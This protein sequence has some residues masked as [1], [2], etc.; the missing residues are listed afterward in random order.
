MQRELPLSTDSFDPAT[1]W[2]DK[3]F[4]K[5][6]VMVGRWNGNRIVGQT[7][8]VT[9]STR[10]GAEQTALDNVAGTKRLEARARLATP[11]DLGC[12]RDDSAIRKP[13]AYEVT[14]ALGERELIFADL[15]TPDDLK[16]AAMPLYR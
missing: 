1:Y 12:V 10:E 3:P 2:A 16:R 13:Y 6:V 5:W 4:K 9:A 7:L 15:A 11:R 14:N 8:Y